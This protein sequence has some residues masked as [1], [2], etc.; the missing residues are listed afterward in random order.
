MS[1]KTKVVSVHGSAFSLLGRIGWY[2]PWRCYCW[3]PTR[4][5]E[6]RELLMSAGCLR[7]LAG[8][9]DRLMADWRLNGKKRD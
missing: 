7:E 3:K 9:L 8:E 1:G 4:V 5:K 2:A 6:G